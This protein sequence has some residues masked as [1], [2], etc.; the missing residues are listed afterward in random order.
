M[1]HNGQTEGRVWHG[2]CWT[3]GRV[4]IYNQARVVRVPNRT[5]YSCSTDLFVGWNTSYSRSTLFAFSTTGLYSGPPLVLIMEPENCIRTTMR[6]TLIDPA[7]ENI[8]LTGHLIKGSYFR[9]PIW[10]PVGPLPEWHVASMWGKVSQQFWAMP[11]TAGF[12][13][14]RNRNIPKAHTQ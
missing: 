4:M 14:D 6:N 8:Q 10:S 7:I 1:S 2:A 13:I 3:L 9:F 11:V 5:D 12:V